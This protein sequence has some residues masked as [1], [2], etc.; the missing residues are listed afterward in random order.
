MFP[1]MLYWKAMSGHWVKYS[2][3]NERFIYWAHPKI[4][5]VLLDVQNG[6]LLWSPIMLF[7][8]WSLVVK[9]KDPRTNA[10]GTTVVLVIITYLFASWWAWWFG[11]AFG[12]R[13]YID[14]YPLLAFPLAVTMESILGAKR[15]YVKILLFVVI[16]LFCYY[17]VAMATMYFTGGM[18]D[19]PAWQWNYDRWWGLVRKTFND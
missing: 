18:W 4:A 3:E 1:Q 9:R 2:Y 15:L 13:C 11:G 5:E 6:W 7:L 16:T 19:G 12:H 10:L 17:S 8:F 14:Y